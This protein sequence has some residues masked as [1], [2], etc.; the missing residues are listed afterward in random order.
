MAD[1]G[2]SKKGVPSSRF[3]IAIVIIIAGLYFWKHYEIRFDQISGATFHRRN[4]AGASEN[5]PQPEETSPTHEVAKPQIDAPKEVPPLTTMTIAT[6]DLTPLSFEKLTDEK[7]AEQI[8]DVIADYDLIAVQ[9][10]ARTTQPLDEIIRRINAKGKVYAYAIPK[11][12]GIAPEYVAYIFDTKIVKYDPGKTYDLV[13][14]TLSHRPL[15]ASFCAVQPSVDKAFTFNLVNVKIPADRSDLETRVLG[16]IFRQVRDHDQAED[17][18]IMLG[19]FGKPIRLINSL[20]GVPY[21][22]VVHD[23]EPTTIDE[24]DSTENIVFDNLRTI[25]CIGN[26][27]IA[28]LIKRF[29]M[30][31]S[32]AGAIAGHLPVSAEFSVFEALSQ[33]PNEAQ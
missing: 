7:R 13:E 8:A 9:G 11:H 23:G 3:I 20:T 33:K 24:S 32:E 12:N 26:A 10:V 14:P 18:I 21:L 29:D 22:S 1:E 5:K 15:V 2:K 30:K 19:N 16:Q 17:D 28:D 6:W 31:L 27:K 4:A 25:E